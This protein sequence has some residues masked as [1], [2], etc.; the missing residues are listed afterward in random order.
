MHPKINLLITLRELVNISRRKYAMDTLPFKSSPGLSP[1]V[2]G[3]QEE[4]EKGPSSASSSSS[5]K[6]GEGQSTKGRVSVPM[7]AQKDTAPKPPKFVNPPPVPQYS[8]EDGLRRVPPYQFSYNTYCK[9]RWR[10]KGVLEVF[11][12]EFRDRPLEYY[13]M[14]GGGAQL[15]SMQTIIASVDSKLENGDMLVH[16]LHRHEPPVTAKP[17]ETVYEDDRLIVINKPAGVPVHPAGRYNFNTVIEI[18]KHDYNGHAPLPCNRL[19]RLTS[20]LMFMAKTPEAANDFMG[21]LQTRTIK[22]QYLARVKGKFPAGEVTCSQPIL[23]VSPKLGLNRVRASGK[24]AKTLFKRLKYNTEKNYSI[25]ECHPFTGRTH[26]IRVHL[27]FLGHPI[28]NDPIYCNRNVWG[29]ALGKGG[30]GEDEEII[31]RLNKVGREEEVRYEEI[32][33][34]YEGRKAEKLTGKRCEVCDT[35]LFSD[36]GLHELGIYLHAKR[37]ECEDGQWGYETELPEWATED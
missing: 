25:V 15:A 21:Q 5:S 10:G 28:I 36:P 31:E 17:I 37:Y 6:A 32:I 22:K 4:V 20:G 16:T 33:E 19:D 30:E 34:D 26:Q 24:T 3:S 8:F 13:G 9:E 7:V 2:F 12:S 29:P 35:P 14:N 11:W 23:S 1:I 18:M 27:Q